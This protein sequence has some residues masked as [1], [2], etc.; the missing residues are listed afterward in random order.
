MRSTIL[1][2]IVFALASFLLTASVFA[3]QVVSWTTPSSGK[4]ETSSEWSGGHGPD[5]AS[6]VFIT[7]AVSKVITIDSTTTSS[8][9]NSLVINS[10]VLNAPHGST[11]TLS[12]TNGGLAVPLRVLAGLSIGSDGALSV[13]NS[14][15][16]VNGAMTM[17]EGDPIA[18]ITNGSLTAGSLALGSAILNGG[19]GTLAIQAGAVVTVTSNITAVSPGAPSSINIAGGSL[20][21]TNGLTQ[22]GASGHAQLLI[23][24]GSHILRQVWLGSPNPSPFSSGSLILSGGTLTVQGTGLGA[25]AGLALSAGGYIQDGGDME[26]SGTSFTIAYYPHNSTAYLSNGIANWGAVYL[27]YSPGYTGTYVQAGGLMTVANNMVIGDNCAQG[28]GSVYGSVMLLGGTLCVT[29]AT[30]T[31]WLDVRNGQ[32]L[33]GSNATLIVDNLIVTNSC[34]QFINSGGTLIMT[35]NPPILSPDMDADGDGQ[36]NGNEA[37]AGTDPLDPT[38]YFHILS[39]TL[40]NSTGLSQGN[41]KDIRIDWTSVGQ[42]SYVVQTNSNLT[43]SAFYDLSPVLTNTNPATIPGT[44]TYIHIG[45]ATNATRYY[46]LRLGP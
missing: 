25:G 4:W 28:N 31:A 24:G 9:T 16:L 34:G 7:N 41:P 2:V 42:H 27:G 29:N 40:T 39:T 26:G 36:S 6:Y 43:S 30:H 37:L 11:N 44:N 17:N 22:L 38:S 13:N 5:S 46:R 3:Q 10:L 19:I 1:K 21:A 33:L 35:N 45:G 15:L 14:A 20:I 18:I 8:F 32:F 12:L 23:S